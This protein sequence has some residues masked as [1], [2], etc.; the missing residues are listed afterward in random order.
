MLHRAVLPLSLLLGLSSC[1]AMHAIPLVFQSPAVCLARDLAK[2]PA[3]R[4]VD[5]YVLD[6]GTPLV[7]YG[8]IDSGGSQMVRDLTFN[9]RQSSAPFEATG[10]FMDG[11][12]D[13]VAPLVGKLREDCEVALAWNDQVVITRGNQVLP[14]RRWQ[15][16]P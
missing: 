13:P 2:A 16:T 5:I 12:G 6:D 9:T 1:A 11:G 3:I 14:R 15:A 10:D 7:E 4:S 8:F